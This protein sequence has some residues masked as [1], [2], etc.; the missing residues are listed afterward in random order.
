M[1]MLAK[2]SSMNT[3]RRKARL[4]EQHFDDPVLNAL[5]MK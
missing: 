4:I 3:T 5:G 2:D 1:P